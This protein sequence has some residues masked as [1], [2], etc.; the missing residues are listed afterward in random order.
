MAGKGQKPNFLWLALLAAAVLA[1]VYFLLFHQTDHAPLHTPAEHAENF[2]FEPV[3]FTGSAEHRFL[4]S[5]SFE[6]PAEFQIISGRLRFFCQGPPSLTRVREIPHPP[7]G[8]DGQL[9][10][11][12]PAD[13]M[14]FHIYEAE[15]EFG[16]PSLWA[17]C[18]GE[19]GEVLVHLLLDFQNGAVLLSRIFSE[20]NLGQEQPAF[21]AEARRFAEKYAWGH[22]G[23][24]PEEKHSLHGRLRLNHDCRHFRGNVKFASPETEFEIFWPGAPLPS[25]WPEEA[26]N[27][28]SR[29]L[30]R[31]GPRSL[32][33]RPGREWV[34]LDRGP[35]LS[36]PALAAVWHPEAE[37]DAALFMFAPAS[38]A[39]PA[40]GYWDFVLE[41]IR[42]PRPDQR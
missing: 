42:F 38:E 26:D 23:A 5:L 12:I 30:F 37:E 16:R 3:P 2:Q 6:L 35:D 10:D 19:P 1:A 15:S 13:P 33:G 41:S 34:T 21:A 36:S 32:D 39:A 7:M 24:E 20:D 40:L 9:A 25:A 8:R 29:L 11:L 31:S 28:E 22:E 27:M 18:P 17:F 14:P 4:G